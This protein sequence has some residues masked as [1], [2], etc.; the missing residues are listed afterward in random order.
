MRSRRLIFKGPCFLLTSAFRRQDQLG[1]QLIEKVPVMSVDDDLTSSS[2]SYISCGLPSLS[3][4]LFH[5]HAS[6]ISFAPNR[7]IATITR[8]WS[9]Q[10]SN[11]GELR[12]N[13]H[14]EDRI[15]HLGKLAN[16]VK[17]NSGLRRERVQRKNLVQ[18]LY[19]SFDRQYPHQGTFRHQLRDGKRNH[20]TRPKM[21][22]RQ[23]KSARRK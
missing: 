14:R 18:S 21:G 2:P 19:L 11:Y 3:S 23:R 8:A 5:R 12:F 13:N 20:Q 4:N 22:R 15:A 7:P 1:N 10:I 16:F 6:P 9:M 17:R